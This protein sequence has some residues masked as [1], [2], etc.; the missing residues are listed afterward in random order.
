MTV[1]DE[2]IQTEI[3]TTNQIRGWSVEAQAKLRMELENLFRCAFTK[4]PKDIYKEEVAYTFKTPKTS[5]KNLQRQNILY[6]SDTHQLIAALIFDYG[7]ITYKEKTMK[8]IYVLNRIVLPAYQTFGIGKSL[9]VKVL[10]EWQPDVLFTTCGQ[11]SSFHSWVELP[12]KG[13]ITGFEV[14]PRLEENQNGT[15]V[16]TVPSKERDFAISAFQQTYLGIAEGKQEAVN[17]A[18]NNLTGLMVRKDMYGARY[19]FHP[20]KKNGREDELA[21]MLGVTQN[22]GILVIFRKKDEK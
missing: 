20:W 1:K 12:Q 13:L 16:V 15:M 8:G 7:D 21:K 19:D 10:L 18:V 5:G 22:D 3:I 9:A 2:R 11:S 4:M 17:K 14:Y 6:R